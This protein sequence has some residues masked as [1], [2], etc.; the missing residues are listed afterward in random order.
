MYR[1]ILVPLDGSAAA[2]RA[3][4][5][6]EALA[7]ATGA[8]LL[9]VRATPADPTSPTDPNAEQTRTVRE[10]EAY[11]AGAAAQLTRCSVIETAVFSGEAA[12]AIL[13]ESRLR[14]VDLV[15]MA[16]CRDSVLGQCVYGEVAEAVLAQS[17]VPLLL[18]R[19]CQAEPQPIP[20]DRR[21]RVLV[22]LDG[23]TFAEEAL[24]AAEC[25]AQTIDGELVLLHVVQPP[26]RARLADSA[27]AASPADTRHVA[28]LE[29]E[30][31]V[32]KSEARDYLQQVAA[33]WASGSGTL[34]LDVR[35]G[36][37]SET[38]AAA[39]RE[40]QAAV[41]ALATHGRTGLSRLLLGSVADSVLQH[42][43]VPL[44]LVRPSAMRR[45]V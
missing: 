18:V 26:R 44:L 43:S 45:A 34:H 11:L 28:L 9:L 41:V 42:S 31:E 17:P 30:L 19:A 12:H 16:T 3:L 25:M 15:A 36:E 37:P 29:H 7:T 32:L 10:V 21:P 14:S 2:E 5:H 8:R 27:S 20:L 24:P 39:V 40:H 13:E 22:P 4:P 1:T 35:V 6:A 38:I 23:S 33:W